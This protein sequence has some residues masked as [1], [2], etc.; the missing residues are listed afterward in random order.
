MLT[1]MLPMLTLLPRLHPPPVFV[2]HQA[3]VRLLLLLLLTLV[4]F[5]LLVLTCAAPFSR[6]RR[7]E[8]VRPGARMAA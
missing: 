8:A 3:T 7:R 4:C 1:L 2:L 6:R 5:C